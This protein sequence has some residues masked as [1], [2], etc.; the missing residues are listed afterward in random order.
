MSPAFAT[1]CCSV[2]SSD[3]NGC[4]SATSAPASPAAQ[5]FE[6][7]GWHSEPWGLRALVFSG[8]ADGTEAGSKLLDDGLMAPASCVER[9]SR[10]ENR[11]RSHV[12]AQW[13][14][15]VARSLDT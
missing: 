1:T 12:S 2:G 8:A 7:W 14:G 4:V 13:I 3:S 6:A 10:R 15:F 9:K 5:R 11:E